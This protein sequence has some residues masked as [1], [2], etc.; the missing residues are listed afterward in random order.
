M[1]FK[2][3]DANAQN[4]YRKQTAELK[5]QELALQREMLEAKTDAQKSNVQ[6]KV[7]T[8]I[9][10]V[11]TNAQDAIDA[12]TQSINISPT[13]N[14]QEKADKIAE[15]KRTIN[16]DKQTLINALKGIGADSGLTLPA[17]DVTTA[18]LT[19]SELV[20]SAEVDLG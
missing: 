9:S 7:V 8:A 2:I 18:P 15:A 19:T 4:R 11:N 6:S 10:E 12:A 17:A 1:A 14:K 16:A 5:G 3:L 13:L 20:A